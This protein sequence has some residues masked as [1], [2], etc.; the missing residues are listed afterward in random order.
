[1]VRIFPGTCWR[2]QATGDG[3]EGERYEARR[4]SIDRAV[5]VEGLENANSEGRR[6]KVEQNGNCWHCGASRDGVR[7]CEQCDGTGSASKGKKRSID[8]GPQSGIKKRRVSAAAVEGV[9]PKPRRGRP[10]GGGKKKLDAIKEE[11]EIN[12]FQPL[13]DGNNAFQQESWHPNFSESSFGDYSWGPDNHHGDP[14]LPSYGMNHDSDPYSRQSNS[15]PAFTSHQAF[16]QQY[17]IMADFTL[18]PQQVEHSTVAYEDCLYPSIEFDHEE[19]HRESG[20][21]DVDEGVNCDPNLGLSDV[22]FE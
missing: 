2:C 5:V 18:N 4:P 7:D 1:M 14:T 12:T 9:T 22:C 17:G 21:A 6:K 16:P 13:L 10:P 11:T 8:E 19:S 3:L 15:M 20:I